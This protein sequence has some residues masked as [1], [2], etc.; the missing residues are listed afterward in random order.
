MATR[1]LVLV[2]LNWMV[3]MTTR[4]SR[5]PREISVNVRSEYHEMF[6]NTW[7]GRGRERER[8]THTQTETEI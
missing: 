7:R 6:F 3:R 5:L 1:T 2:M 8:E 4:M